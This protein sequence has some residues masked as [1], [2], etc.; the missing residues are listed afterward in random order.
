[1]PDTRRTGRAGPPK[2]PATVRIPPVPS[3]E[4]DAAYFDAARRSSRSRPACS[5]ASARSSGDERAV[6]RHDCGP[7]RRAPGRG[8]SR[9]AEDA[10]WQ[11]VE[12]TVAAASRPDRSLD[13]DVRPTSTCTTRR[14]ARCT[15]TTRCAPCMAL[16]RQIPYLDS[17]GFLRELTLVIN[18][19]RDQHT[20]LYVNAADQS[21]TPYVA[22]LPVPRRGVR[23][24]P[25]RRPTSSPRSA[26]TVASDPASARV[27]GSP[28]GTASRSRGRS[29]STPR[30]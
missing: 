16:R 7:P 28:P 30:P 23:R 5:R 17:A 27:C 8:R 11:P 2:D 9:R 18:R 6:R 21:L 15:A 26:T 3:I 10:M 14:S 25:H 22:A 29:T 12:L 20:Q 19:L 4:H 1:M 24:V 13:D